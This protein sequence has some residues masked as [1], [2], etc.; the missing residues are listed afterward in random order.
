MSTIAVPIAG[1]ANAAQVMAGWRRA[2]KALRPT[3][4]DEEHDD[5]QEGDDSAGIRVRRI[6]RRPDE[7]RSEQDAAHDGGDPTD[8]HRHEEPPKVTRDRGSVAEMEMGIDGGQDDVGDVERPEVARFKERAELVAVPGSPPGRIEA[9]QDRNHASHSITLHD[10]SWTDTDPST[11]ACQGVNR[12]VLRRGLVGY[13]FASRFSVSAR[14]FRAP[15]RVP[16]MS[17]AGC[18]S[19]WPGGGVAFLVRPFRRASAR[20]SMRWRD[21]RLVA[22]VER[23]EVAA[24]AEVV[25]Q[26][27]LVDVGPLVVGR[28]AIADADAVRLHAPIGRV[29]QVQRHGQ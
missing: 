4:S 14:R 10:I 16:M 19:P 20:A 3:E 2:W 1:T 8:A 11:R 12:A 27:L 7:S 28:V 6:E 22:V 15:S 25:G 29:A 18:H 17:P 5:G 24:V 9:Q 21:R 23:V 13:A 26:V